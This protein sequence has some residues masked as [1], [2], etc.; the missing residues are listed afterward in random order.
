MIEAYK[1]FFRNYVNFEGRANRAEYWWVVLCNVIIYL[2]CIFLGLMIAGFQG[3]E[4]TANLVFSMGIGIILMWIYGLA[5]I[6]PSISLTVRRLHDINLSGWLC[7]LGL[8]PYI[9]GLIVFIMTLIK[10][11]EGENKYGEPSTFDAESNIA[12]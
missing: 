12:N 3:D 1:R 6:I 10:G 2:V 8:I 11:T 9:G 4:I 5:T 7:L